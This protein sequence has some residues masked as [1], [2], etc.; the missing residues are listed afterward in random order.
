MTPTPSDRSIQRFDEWGTGVFV[1]CTVPAVLLEGPVRAFAAVV[2]GGLFLIGCVVFL[3]AFSRALDRSRREMIGIGG[4]YF[5]AGCAPSSVRRRLLTLLA[6]QVV[7][8]TVAAA[9]R[10]F[11][12]LAVGVLVPMFGLGL[13]GLWG[14]LHGEFPARG[15]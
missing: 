3:W 14:A 12:S 9:I 11:T 5:L 15:G 4:L 1:V 13:C 10:P 6:A 2:A 7:V 8:A